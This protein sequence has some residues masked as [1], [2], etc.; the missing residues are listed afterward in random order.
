[1]LDAAA[2]APLALPLIS[3]DPPVQPCAYFSLLLLL[4]L[5]NPPFA[6]MIFYIFIFFFLLLFGP[7]S[8]HNPSVVA[9]LYYMP[10]SLDQF[11]LAPSSISLLLEQCLPLF[12][13]LSL[14]PLLCSDFCGNLRVASKI[15]SIVIH[16]Y[17]Y[18]CT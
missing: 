11:L 7:L 8:A 10:D 3:T 4:H 15:N 13:M 6:N 16:K 9:N 2:A 18:V 14:R 5:L 12:L 1:M 17:M